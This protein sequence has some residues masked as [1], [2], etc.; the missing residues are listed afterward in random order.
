M[1]TKVVAAP[2]KTE[3]YS[4]M[5]L[6]FYAIEN[7]PSRLHKTDSIFFNHGRQIFS[8]LSLVNACNL[9]GKTHRTLLIF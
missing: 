4:L 3:D 1:K 2:W 8:Y 7:P 5:P 6:I 9:T